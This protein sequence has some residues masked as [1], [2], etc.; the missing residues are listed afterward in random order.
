MNEQQSVVVQGIDHSAFWR[1]VVEG[2]DAVVVDGQCYGIG[3]DKPGRPNH[4]KGFGG[5]K[6]LVTFH[7]GRTV[8]TD[9][10]WHRGR[11]PD[12]FR[13]L[14][15]DNATLT[16]AECPVPWLIDRLLSEDLPF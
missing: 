13:A 7:D 8:R 15:P 4:C 16:S 3:D 1:R 6:W 5:R 10:L 11:V 12:A 14:L 9:N 2:G